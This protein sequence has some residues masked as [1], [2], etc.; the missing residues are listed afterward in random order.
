M[1]E[2]RNSIDL[3]YYVSPENEISSFKQ[4]PMN[5][6]DAVRKMFKSSFDSMAFRYRFRGARRTA[7]F[8]PRNNTAKQR[9]CL[10]RNAATFAVYCVKKNLY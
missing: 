1:S 6:Y 10:K 4:I 3:Q 9:D 5:H 7:L 2:V 8:D